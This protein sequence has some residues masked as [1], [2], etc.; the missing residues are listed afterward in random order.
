ML[1]KQASPKD[2]RIKVIARYL[3]EDCTMTELCGRRH[4]QIHPADDA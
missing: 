1:W 3:A 4:G 2:E